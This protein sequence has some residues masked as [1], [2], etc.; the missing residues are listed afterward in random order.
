MNQLLITIKKQFL[1]NV[2]H[3]AKTDPAW[4][5]RS[6]HTPNGCETTWSIRIV[7]AVLK[8]YNFLTPECPECGSPYGSHLAE[9][10]CKTCWPKK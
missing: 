10:N 8:R 1:Q 5:L 7:R 4:L 9:W 6:Y 3:L 2:K